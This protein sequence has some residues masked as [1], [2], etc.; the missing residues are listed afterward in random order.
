MLQMISINKSG[1][2][3]KDRLTGKYFRCDEN[4]VWEDSEFVSV[5]NYEF[6]G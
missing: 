1:G 6:S 4:I 5:K 3:A 2:D